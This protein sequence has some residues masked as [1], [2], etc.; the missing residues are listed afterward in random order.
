MVVLTN[1]SKS[2]DLTSVPPGSPVT[3][4]ISVTNGSPDGSATNPLVITDTLPAGMTY[5]SGSAT[6]NGGAIPITATQSGQTLTLTPTTQ[7]TAGQTLTLT[8]QVNMPPAATNEQIY[9]NAISV[10]GETGGQP[11]VAST[12]AFM[13]EYG[14]NLAG[15][16]SASPNYVQQ[17]QPVSFTIN[18][19]NWGTGPTTGLRVTD[20]LP[21]GISLIPGSL[22]AT[23][24]GSP[25]TVSNSG[26]PT[27]LNLNFGQEIPPKGSLSLTFQG[28]TDSATPCSMLINTATY[29]AYAGD[30]GTTTQPIYFWITPANAPMLANAVKTMTPP[31]PGGTITITSTVA[32]NGTAPTNSLTFTDNLP[33]FLTYAAGTGAGTIAGA[34]VTVTDDGNATSPTFTFGSQLQPGQSATVTFTANVSSS[35]DNST[36]ANTGTW[37][38]EGGCGLCGATSSNGCTCANGK[39]NAGGLYY[40]I[41]GYGSCAN[42]TSTPT[43]NGANTIVTLVPSPKANGTNGSSFFLGV[44]NTTGTTQ[45]VQ[46]KLAVPPG[47]SIPTPLSY[48]TQGGTGNSTT[49]PLSLDSDGNIVGTMTI[50][51][52][53][54]ALI[55]NNSIQLMFNVDPNIPDGTELD[56]VLT[57]VPPSV[58]GTVTGALSNMASPA[59]FIIASACNS[60]ISISKNGPDIAN[61]G[62]TIT[63]TSQ[64]TNNTTSTSSALNVT[65]SLPAGLTLVGSPTADINGTPTTVTV[66]GTSTVPIFKFGDP[67]P[68][69]ATLNLSYQA[70]I[71]TT[72]TEGTLFTNIIYAGL[73]S[74][75][76]TASASTQTIIPS[77]DPTVNL[78]KTASPY[79]NAGGTVTYTLNV[80][81]FGIPDLTS[82]SINDLLPAGFTYIPNSA[83]STAAVPLQVG[84]TVSNPTFSWPGLTLETADTASVTFLAQAPANLQSGTVTN[85][86]TASANPPQGAPVTDSDSADTVTVPFADL[87]ANKFASPS[88]VPPGGTI[89][90]VISVVNN[91]TAPTTA[92]ALAETLPSGVTYVSGSATGTV[93]GMPATITTGG[94]TSKPTFTFGTQIPVGGSAQLTFSAKVSTSARNGAVLVN[95]ATVTPDGMTQV[96]VTD[97]GVT[98]TPL[99]NLVTASKSASPAQVAAGGLVTYTVTIPNTGTA[100]T[101]ALAVVDNLPSGVTYAGNPV[102]TVNGV[103][104]TVTVTGTSQQPQFT[105]GTQLPSGQTA[106]LTFQAHVDGSVAP[107][108]ILVNHANV[109]PDGNT[110]IPVTAQNQV[111]AQVVGLTLKK[112]VAASANPVVAGTVLTYT[113]TVQNTGNC[114][115]TNV[116]IN[117]PKFGGNIATIPTLAAGATDSSTTQTYTVTQAD[118]DN[119]ADILNTATA[120]GTNPTDNTTVPSEP[121]TADVP[122]PAPNPVLILNKSVNPPKAVAGDKVTY[123]FNVQNG[124][125]VTLTNVVVNDSML[126]GNILTFDSLAPGQTL[127]GQVVYTLT[128]ADA[129]SGTIPNTATAVSTDPKGNPVESS[130]STAVVTVPAADL[131]VTITADKPTYE[132]GDPILYTI[133]VANN[134]PD[135][136]VTPVLSDNFPTELEDLSYSTDGGNTWAPYTGTIQFPD[137]SPNDPPI[138][139][140]VK[141][142]VGEGTPPMILPDTVT[143][144]SPV[145]PDSNPA[146]NQAEVD[147]PVIDTADLSLAKSADPATVTAG[148]VITYTLVAKNN[149]PGPAVNTVVTDT[150]PSEVQDPQY[151]LDGGTTW[152]PWTG[153]VGLGTMAMGDSKTVLISGLVASSALGSIKNTAA[154]KSD[155]PDDVPGND[156]PTIN[157]PI[158]ALA[159]VSVVKTANKDYVDS[160]NPGSPAIVYTLNVSNAGPS[161]AHNIQVTDNLPAQLTNGQFSL[162]GGATWNPWTGSTSIGSL[163]AGSSNII[164]IS[165]DWVPDTVGVIE[166]TATVKTPTPSPNPPVPSTVKTPIDEA[167][168][169]V[170]VK[171]VIDPQQVYLDGEQVNY[172]ISVTNNGPVDAPN[173]ILTDLVPTTLKGPITYSLAGGQTQ[174]WGGSLNLGTVLVGETVVVDFSAYVNTHTVVSVPNTA[175]VTSDN[176]NPVPEDGTSKV[177]ISANGAANLS[178]VKTLLTSPVVAGA[179]VAYTMTVSNAGPDDAE[180][181]V[182]TDQ[183]DSNLLSPEYSL[184]G[185]NY[186]AYS[187][188]N[189]ISLGTIAVGAQ[190]VIY[191][192]GVVDPSA[193]ESENFN[194]TLSNTASVSSSTPPTDVVPH[195]SNT[196]TAPIEGSADVQVTKDTVPAGLTPLVAGTDVTYQLAVTNNGPSVAENVLLV[197]AIPAS[198]ITPQY[199]FSP[200]G[201]WSTWTGK[202]MLG[203][204]DAGQSTSVYIQGTISRALVDGTTTPPSLANTATVLSA[205][206]DPLPSNNSSTVTRPVAAQADLQAVKVLYGQSS[207]TTGQQV[208]YIMKVLNSGSSNAEN[209]MMVDSIPDGLTNVQY[210][211]DSGLTWTPWGGSYSVPLLGAGTGR[212]VLIQGTAAGNTTGLIGNSAAMLSTT[213][214][215]NPNNNTVRVDVPYT[216][217]DLTVTKVPDVPITVVGQ[218]INYDITVCNNGDEDAPD[219]QYQDIMDPAS[220]AGIQ[221]SM[222]GGVTWQDWPDNSTINLG[223]LPAGSCTSFKMRGV[224]QPHADD[225]VDSTPTVSSGTTT[226]NT[227]VFTPLQDLADLTLLKSVSPVSASVGDTVTY[228]FTI[229]NHGPGHADDY[230]LFDPVDPQLSGMEY[231]TDG[232]ST[233]SPWTGSYEW[234][235]PDSESHFWPGMTATVLLRGTLT[236]KFIGSYQNTAVVSSTTADPDP[237]NNVGTATVTSDTIILSVTK[238]PD[239]PF[240][241]VGDT[242]NY[243]VTVCNNGTKDAENALYQDIPTEASGD[244][245]YSFDGGKTWLDWPTGNIL[246]LGTLVAGTCTTFLTRSVVQP[247]AD[248]GVDYNP[249]VTSGNYTANTTVFTPLVDVADLEIIKTSSISTGKAGDIVTY[250]LTVNNH[251]PGHADDYVIIDQVEPQLSN[252]EYSLDNGN[253]WI[254]WTGSYEWGAPDSESHFWPGM[255]ASILLR[256]TLTGALTGDYTNT[257]FVTSTSADPNPS[258]NYDSTTLVI[259]T[260]VEVEVPTVDVTVTQTA[261]KTCV[262]PGKPLTYSIQVA[263]LGAATASNVVVFDDMPN[264]VRCGAKYSLDRGCTW[265]TWT[266]TLE[267]G[268]IPANGNKELQI[269]ITPP[270]SYCKG[271]EHKVYAY[272]QSCDANP[273]N[274]SSALK[275]PTCCQKNCNCRR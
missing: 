4:T 67:L 61:A 5:I 66:S 137:I 92:F 134:G 266:G 48:S 84:G 79:V 257:A 186:T 161:D 94:T 105:F 101:T 217:V 63:Y 251:G 229:A 19:S 100:A 265:C 237:S 91:G 30:S 258:N 202:V 128:A 139:V 125:N 116:V 124:G 208:T 109:T 142:T 86:A 219:T 211:V 38:A 70:L 176:P 262:C 53:K 170:V 41:Y 242:I 215:P 75:S 40:S 113:F 65:D 231:S 58:P 114:P 247:H 131:V 235:A 9:T 147:V 32:N 118:I 144:Q 180:D 49:G 106:V 39:V 234:G 120:T 256:G 233:W 14:P 26:T 172:Q 194:P 11:T 133:T 21:S 52:G 13:T 238:V 255:T 241:V 69:G 158:Q 179:P 98:V 119:G 253:S 195:T 184:D 99:P 6:G 112:T 224:V 248:D 93:N 20:V 252:P 156:T 181:V 199:A 7:L 264:S 163:A 43:T 115:L 193:A 174:Q 35:Y 44:A 29:Y 214:D 250:L 3:Y 68:G 148:N 200:D 198:I 10:T 173:T 272:T 192:R 254:P 157:T 263:N 267:I 56:F 205:T 165:A 175:T 55:G 81:N 216:N 239:V 168:H 197:D 155:V 122:L 2:S 121:S 160:N 23:I 78:T 102:A 51:N 64:I 73:T 240:T 152:N 162:D 271:I 17:G 203:D 135:T 226:A 107:Q 103:S 153:Q 201:P 244:I 104:S 220:F 60:N 210:S 45:Q 34:S 46:V 269:K 218:T 154:V 190:A 108:T 42:A 24:N 166:N 249:V 274:N 191:F 127:Q 236:D 178:M 206:P 54:T 245:Q 159:D 169:L 188:D 96:P 232:G 126:G 89:Q 177:Y 71:P 80:T 268:D 143:I 171:T 164:L 1:V 83:T 85:N 37:C 222:D 72:E 47:A 15:S 90:Y 110:Q 8:F 130:P 187:S 209:V 261:N 87:N 31:I 270:K 182:V 28:S 132:P 204:M 230:I 141:G 16:K 167:S 74:S 149:G 213:K 136:S 97:N 145:T 273:T 57:T 77:D 151:S 138:T 260:D 95:N 246:A 185:V 123:T 227:T 12:S 207:A 140:L 25:V 111:D 88:I 62:D 189:P 259:P 146:N 27:S 129:A 36:I 228:T 223:T 33:N 117:D 18:I 221:Y 22:S 275:L 76:L 82:P 59:R 150:L 243:T 212:S 183:L 196:V 225:G 50:P